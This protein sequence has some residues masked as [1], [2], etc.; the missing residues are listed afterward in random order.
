[1]GFS[2]FLQFF[3]KKGEIKSFSSDYVNW[4]CERL[5]PARFDSSTFSFNGINNIAK[6]I[7]KESAN[8]EYCCS[9]IVP[10]N[11]PFLQEIRVDNYLAE[12]KINRETLKD[13]LLI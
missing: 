12:I 9:V 5:V 4:T 11:I 13:Y 8:E 7:Q 1:M 2:A 6:S 10:E 3:D